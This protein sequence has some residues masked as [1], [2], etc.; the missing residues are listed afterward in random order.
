MNIAK[1]FSELLKFNPYHGK[2]GRFT[3]P[4]GYASF[5]ANPNTKAGKLAIRREQK[6]NPLVGAAYGTKRTAGQIMQEKRDKQSVTHAMKLLSDYEVSENRKALILDIEDLY[7]TADRKGNIRLKEDGNV[8]V[9]RSALERAKEISRKAADSATQMDYST[10]AEYDEIRSYVKNTPLK[11][12]QYDRSNIADFNDY[13]RS[14][15]GNVTISNKGTP[16]D[17]FYQQ[18]AGQYPHLFDSKSTTTP[19]DQ[20]TSIND[21]ISNL[22]PRTTKLSGE[23]KEQFIASMTNDIIRGYI[24]K[25]TDLRMA[26][27]FSD[28]L[29]FN[30]YHGKDGRFTGPNGATSFTYAPG[31]SK[32]HDL[33]IEREKKR[34]ATASGGSQESNKYRGRYSGGTDK[35]LAGAESQLKDYIAREEK[36]IASAKYMS[37]STR[38]EHLSFHNDSLKE[39]KLQMQELQR[40]KQKRSSVHGKAP[41]LDEIDRAAEKLADLENERKYR[42]DLMTYKQKQEHAKK[43]D[44]ARKEYEELI[45]RA[46]LPKQRKSPDAL[47]FEEDDLFNAFNKSKTEESRENTFSI[48]KK[49]EEKRLVFG[50]ANV[51]IRANGEQVLD[52]Q[53]DMVDPE[54]LEEGVY[55]YVLNFRDAG[56]EHMPGYRKKARMVESVM[57]TEEKL[58]AMGIPKGTVPLGWWI[59]FYVDDDDTWEKI[60]NGT[61]TM[62]S[63]EGR[64]TRLPVKKSAPAAQSFNEIMKFNPYHGKDGRFTGPNGATSFTYAPGK[65]KAHDLAIEREKKR[66]AAASGGYTSSITGTTHEMPK[67]DSEQAERDR[68]TALR[69]VEQYFSRKTPVKQ[70]YDEKMKRY[71]E[72]TDAGEWNKRAHKDVF[73]IGHNFVSAKTPTERKQEAERRHDNELR[74]KALDRAA[75]KR[76]KSFERYKDYEQSLRD[77]YTK[78]TDWNHRDW[79]R[80]ITREEAQKL[81]EL[82][83]A[84]VFR[85]KRGQWQIAK[86]FSEIVKF[87]PYHGKDGR[88]TTANGYDI[89]TIRT[90]DPKK[91]HMADMAI[92][93]EKERSKNSGGGGGSDFGITNE[94][95]EK[96]E[97][98]VNSSIF[99]GKK[100]AQE[101]G[102]SDGDYEK[103]KAK[104]KTDKRREELRQERKAKEAQERRTQEQQTADR[105]KNELPG[106]NQDAIRRADDNSLLGSAGTGRAK[107]ALQRLD[108]F[109]EEFKDNPD[110]TPEQR[111]YVK[112]RQ[113]EYRQLITDYY[114]DQI[115]RTGENVSWAVAGPANYNYRAHD[116]KMNAQMNR[117]N[118]YEQKIQN[119]KDNTHKQLQRLTPEDQQIARWRNGKWERGETIDFA[120]PLASKKLQAKLDYLNEN[121]Q[122]MKDANA[123]YRR[124]KT[125]TGFEGFSEKTNETLNNAINNP[126]YTMSKPFESYSLTNNNQQI[127]ATQSRLNQLAQQK[128]RSKTS[129]G[130]GRS[131]NGGTMRHNSDINRLQL[132]FD[133]KP[134]AEIRDKLKSHGFR[135][136]PR[137]GAWQRQDTPNAEYAANKILEELGL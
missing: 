108:S 3:G 52:L 54:D 1:T 61:Y 76:T 10:K 110:W 57:F 34:T 67:L 73:S 2:D 50:W 85:N 134:S 90:K 42:P 32:A 8:G 135:W 17:T 59:G 13:R 94:Q 30:P 70:K 27:S 69:H 44:A 19:A 117:A 37:G 22:K 64:G 11:I 96:L 136:S 88:F 93:R 72:E 62:F 39:L 49:D 12:S 38:D 14:S 65:S 129:S 4:G 104:Y 121:Q 91:Q 126:R 97:R 124:N 118:E 18:L 113:E 71:L 28:I 105:I 53:H 15:F 51:A 66:T 116:K 114:N 133:G 36:A 131:F 80:N 106:L 43:Q 132:V 20:L 6:N 123:Y 128:E 40:E 55:Q 46:E 95:H 115:R 84:T 74:N 101:I 102:M 58:K 68:A 120:D 82:R 7:R 75:M 60:K 5:S 78:P 122:K 92:A 31:K 16:I 99:A 23:M 127:K 56:E 25:D 21:V 9:K 81:D 100:Y 137:E 111:A 107:E 77:K 29:K 24:M 83:A 35:Q 63:I 26:K 89:F 103:Y 45:S 125:M 112:Q 87:N 79:Y 98:L 86:S 119:F 47:E 130:S 109:K 48:Q 41:T 33:A